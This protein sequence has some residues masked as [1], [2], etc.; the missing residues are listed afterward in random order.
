MS[1]HRR[2]ALDLGDLVVERLE[3]AVIAGPPEHRRELRTP[4]RQLADR[5]GHEDVDHLPVAVALARH[6]AEVDRRAVGLDEFRLDELAAAERAGPRLDEA[7]TRIPVEPLGIGC[8]DEPAESLGQRVLL[9]RSQPG[10]AAADRD[11]RHHPDIEVPADQRLDLGI[12]ALVAELLRILHDVEKRAV[13]M[14]DHLDGGSVGLGGERRGHGRKEERACCEAPERAGTEPNK[15]S[16]TPRAWICVTRRRRL[17]VARGLTRFRIL[18]GAGSSRTPYPYTRSRC[19]AAR[20]DASHMGR[21]TRIA[22][23]A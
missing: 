9:G 15:H 2:L 11:L 5:T 23:C 6:V 3:K 21:L 16:N 8:R 22:P 4:S 7:L 17:G 12:T 20:T 13:E 10:P 1:A 19:A 14:L 18:E